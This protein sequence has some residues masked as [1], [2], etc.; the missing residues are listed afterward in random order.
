MKKYILFFLLFSFLFCMPSVNAVF[1][2]S[3]KSRTQLQNE[4]LSTGFLPAFRYE[5]N[6]IELNQDS[7]VD[8]ILS[9]DSKIVSVEVI[10]A[11][12]LGLGIDDK[13]LVEKGLKIIRPKRLRS[14]QNRG[15]EFSSN[16][17]VFNLKSAKNKPLIIDAID[18]KV[19]KVII[20]GKL[21][22]SYVLQAT[23]DGKGITTTK[24]FTK[25]DFRKIGRASC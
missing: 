19:F 13:T 7:S 20:S 12:A 24:V 2:Y 10:S 23:V 17:A 4:N 3:A 11:K 15:V 21:P 5:R 25:P 16:K 6:N 18:F 9:R 22:G 14:K 8:L 1:I